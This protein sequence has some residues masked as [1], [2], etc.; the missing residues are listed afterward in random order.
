MFKPYSKMDKQRQTAGETATT[1]K[2]D[3]EIVRLNEER[4][5]R[6]AEIQEKIDRLHA[7][8]TNMNTLRQLNDEQIRVHVMERTLINN[9]Y[10]A[11]KAAIREKMNEFYVHPSSHEHYKHFGKFCELH[12]E[13]LA[14]WKEY[15]LSL[16]GGEQ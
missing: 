2:F 5:L 7:Q 1:N 8:N 11:K 3:A 9:E 14:L 6:L 16:E 15:K 13:V 4:D 10:K 12:P